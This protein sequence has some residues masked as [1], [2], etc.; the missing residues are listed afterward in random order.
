MKN[1]FISLALL[2]MALGSVGSWVYAD[3]HNPEILLR[4]EERV[5]ET[6]SEGQTPIV[7]FDLDDTVI[8]TRER[9]IRILK[10]FAAQ[11][12]IQDQFPAAAQVLQGLD[13]KN[14]KYRVTDTLRGLGLNDIKLEEEANSF[15]LPRFFSNEYCVK[16]RSLRG[17]VRYVNR[18]A[19][20]GAKIVYLTGRDVPRMGLGTAANLAARGFPLDF[21]NVLLMM[22]PD[23]KMDDLAFKVEAFQKISEMG[24]V[25][26][27][28]ENEPAN[29]NAIQAR[30]P[31]AISVFLD[32]IHSPKPDVPNSGIHWI[33]DFAYRELATGNY[34]IYA[35][36][37]FPR[38]DFPLGN[39]AVIR[40]LNFEFA[41]VAI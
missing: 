41:I 4:V 23:S 39:T 5:R 32:T 16:D 2:V 29:I 31:E 9:N 18:L 7:I 12:S 19:E 24:T 38:G 37:N 26:A 15:W 20:A 34:R 1:R 10:D 33:K 36:T 40:P 17:A 28:F 21:K 6:V 3:E 8:D 30:F 35:D 22:K 27:G 11:E 14:I 25:V 13:V